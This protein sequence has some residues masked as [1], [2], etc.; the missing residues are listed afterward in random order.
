MKT[1]RNLI[2]ATVA[3]TAMASTVA[4]GPNYVEQRLDTPSERFIIYITHFPATI[5]M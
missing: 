3:A 1:M 2:M 4:A 5:S